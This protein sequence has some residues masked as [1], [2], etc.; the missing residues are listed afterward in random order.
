[1]YHYLPFLLIGLHSTGYK[2][3]LIIFNQYNLSISYRICVFVA[4]YCFL[5]YFLKAKF[6][7]VPSRT[8]VKVGCAVGK[9]RLRNTARGRE[10]RIEMKKQRNGVCGK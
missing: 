4:T 1:M 6:W 5:P 2:G 9:N 10:E 8:I 7:G 3:K